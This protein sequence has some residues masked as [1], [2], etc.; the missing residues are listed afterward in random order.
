MATRVHSLEASRLELFLQHRH[1]PALDGGPESD[2]G[3]QLAEVLRRANDFVPSQA[4]SILLDDPTFL[5]ADRRHNHLTFIAAFGDRAD[6]LIGQEL[7]A[8]QG[9]AGYVYLTGRSHQTS[10]ARDDELFFADFD[11]AIDFHTKALVA[12]P[13]E[14]GQEICGVLELI[15][16][17]PFL[18]G[19]LQLLE[20]FANY[21]SVSIQNFLDARFARS[22][23][24]RDNL[25]ELFNDR[26]LHVALREGIQ[27]STARDE[28]LAVLFLDL[29]N[30]KRVNDTHGHLAGSQ[31]LREVGQLLLSAAP[32]DALS[33]RYG[34]DEFVVVLPGTDLDGAVE[35]AEAVRERLLATVFCQGGGDIHPDPLHL[36][37]QTVSIGV[38]ALRSHVDPGDDETVKTALLH[39]ADAAMY[40]AKETGRNRTAVAARPVAPGTSSKPLR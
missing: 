29:D 30:F 24:K 21:M 7:Q 25:T 22:L 3:A 39:L 8:T 6:A 37:G 26:H 13:I 23:A 15:R 1:R 14:L 34:G 17:E 40:V 32:E 9:I 16:D 5:E 10:A 27:R 36:K 18:A 28:D 19:D 12:V 31:V 4:G 20:I 11:N 35:I 2:L 33:A 38:A